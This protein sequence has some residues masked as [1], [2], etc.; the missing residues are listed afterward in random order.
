[1]DSLLVNTRDWVRRFY[2]L[3]LG[4]LGILLTALSR[5][6]M[7]FSLSTLGLII[8]FLFFSS[9]MVMTWILYYTL[10]HNS[11]NPFLDFF[12]HFKLFMRGDCNR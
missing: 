6:L 9:G 11:M 7:S 3:S 4:S 8:S 5:L 1:M 12:L 2:G 10:R